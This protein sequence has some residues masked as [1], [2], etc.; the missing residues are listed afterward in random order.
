MEL[1]KIPD[2]M[3]PTPITYGE[4]AEVDSEITE[5]T[6]LKEVNIEAC[7]SPKSKVKN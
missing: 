1:A 7:L 2:K 5:E 6:T 3:E 4:N